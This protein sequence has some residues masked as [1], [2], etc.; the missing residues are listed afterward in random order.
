MPAIHVLLLGLLC[1]APAQ[2]RA[3]SR[4]RMG[5][6]PTMRDTTQ[7]REPDSGV[8]FPRELATRDLGMTRAQKL[9][10]LGVNEGMLGKNRDN[11]NAST[12]APAMVRPYRST[13]PT[14]S[15]QSCVLSGALSSP[16]STRLARISKMPL[17]PATPKP[18]RMKISIPSSARPSKNNMMAR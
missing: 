7:V 12:P 6:M 16:A 1:A 13:L 9:V 2:D 14:R 17:T 4:P 10:A 3:E 8:L 18:G 11:T 15:T 5:D